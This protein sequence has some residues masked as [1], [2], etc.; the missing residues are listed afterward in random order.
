MN[1]LIDG[2]SNDSYIV[3]NILVK[4]KGVNKP[5]FVESILFSLDHINLLANGHKFC[6]L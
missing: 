6:M 4:G 2:E 1:S 3:L 5:V